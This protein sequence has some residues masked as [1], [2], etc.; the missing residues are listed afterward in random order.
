MFQA[1]RAF[2][3]AE[4]LATDHDEAGRPGTRDLLLEIRIDLAELL[5]RIGRSA[6]AR[7]VLDSCRP[8]EGS[9]AG[10]CG[11][12]DP[13]VL[14][15]VAIETAVLEVEA[16]RAALARG[17]LGDPPRPGEAGDVRGRWW[18]AAA[19]AAW[20]EGD[21]PRAMDAVENARGA[22]AGDLWDA[23]C[24]G[25]LVVVLGLSGLE[26]RA[27]ALGGPAHLRFL[28]AGMPHEAARIELAVA[29]AL[30]DGARH[31]VAVEWARAA[32]EAFTHVGSAV[33]LAECDRLMGSCHTALGEWRRAEEELSSA[34]RIQRRLRLGHDALQTSRDLA[35]LEIA[36]GRI[37][38]AVRTLNRVLGGFAELG[39]GWDAAESHL[40]AATALLDATAGPVLSAAV[41][42]GRSGESGADS[43]GL[44][45]EAAR[46]HTDKAR[47]VF[48]AAGAVDRRAMC[49]LVLATCDALTGRPGA[50]GR[51]LVIRDSGAVSDEVRAEA[52]RVL[53][54]IR[55]GEGRFADARSDFSK[56]EDSFGRAG[57]PLDAA[58]AGVETAWVLHHEEDPGGLRDLIGP[59]S[60]LLRA[61]ALLGTTADRSSWQAR[62]R[63]AADLAFRWAR[64]T[65]DERLL[66]ELV[67]VWRN[68]R[69]PTITPGTGRAGPERRAATRWV[70]T[71]GA[72]AALLPDSARFRV[73][74]VVRLTMPDG[75][76]AL[77]EWFSDGH[78][79]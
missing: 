48:A 43:A 70:P 41:V 69:V 6:E 45:V 56:A 40:L 12:P 3:V 42:E 20:T 31:G 64:E 59:L 24:D 74:E 35:E 46:D 44:G 77:G 47:R 72:D 22:G 39:A 68:L 29:R 75:S 9:S 65:G 8:G 16:G 2:S 13:V 52:F 19:M 38:R 55:A 15:L 63:D 66:A 26:D 27:E 79:H 23:T 36:A 17:L 18:L 5:R 78:L 58:W 14:R 53:G 49:D 28:E 76:V 54:A 10:Q 21:L 4:G 30:A 25:H 50:E 51:V 73:R 11:D 61:G 1:L 71:R 7:S 62:T 67:E 32:R 34:L 37:D 33:D 57:M 60:H